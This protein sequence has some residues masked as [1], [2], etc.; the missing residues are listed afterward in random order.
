MK[1]SGYVFENPEETHERFIQ[2][3]KTHHR[4]E[5]LHREHLALLFRKW[6]ELKGIGLTEAACR[7]GVNRS[8]FYTWT[9]LTG[10]KRSSIESMMKIIKKHR[11]A[12][13]VRACS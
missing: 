9:K 6:A 2:I 12:E 3:T 1:S 7:L 10:E 11:V 13:Y 8:T 4:I 5:M